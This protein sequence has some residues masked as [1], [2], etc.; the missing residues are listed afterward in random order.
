METEYIC[1][2]EKCIHLFVRPWSRNEQ[3][4]RHEFGDNTRSDVS[5]ETWLGRDYSNRPYKAV[6]NQSRKAVVATMVR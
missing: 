1:L 4:K 3:K 2:S 6:C 5:G